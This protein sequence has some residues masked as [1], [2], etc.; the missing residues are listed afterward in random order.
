MDTQRWSS[1]LLQTYAN[2]I[3]CIEQISDRQKSAQFRHVAPK[4]QTNT[5]QKSTSDTFILVKLVLGVKIN[6]S[7]VTSLVNFSDTRR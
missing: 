7:S 2:I 6:K 3:V 1:R 5:R 4:T